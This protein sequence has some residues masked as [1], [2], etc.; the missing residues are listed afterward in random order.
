MNTRSGDLVLAAITPKY[1]AVPALSLETQRRL[2]RLWLLLTDAA[3]LALAFSIAFWMRFGLL[4]TVEPEVVPNQMF[5]LGLTA[6]LIPVWIL[7]FL[8]FNLYN[9]QM[10]L[11]GIAEYARAFNACTTSSMIVVI[12]AFL[13]PQLIISRAWLALS[14][15]LTFLLV[16]SNR[17][18]NRRLVYTLRERGYFLTP[19]AIIGTNSEA[20]TLA[21]DLGELRHSGLR[22]VGFVRSDDLDG[23]NHPPAIR[24]LG[25]LREIQTIITAHEIEDLIVATTALKRDEL[26]QLGEEV[27][28]IPNVNLR[29]SSGLYELFTT[30]VTVKTIGTVPL[31]S[32][33][34]VR[35]EPEEIYIKSLMDY[36]L[37]LAILFFA[38]PIYLLI[39]LLVKLDSPGPVL[40]RRRVLGGSNRQFDA[41]K[42][43]TMY[44]N[45]DELL[46]DKPELIQQLGTDHK[47]KNDPR[48]TKLGFWL[49]RFSLDELPQLFNVLMGQ[50]SLVGPRMITPAERDK[51][52]LHKLNLLT[53]KPGITGLWQVSGRSDVSYEDRVRL[54][55][56]YIR[57]YSVWLDLQI[58]FVQTLPAVFKS[59]GAY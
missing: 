11:G 9:L 38:W 7:A 55:M 21:S 17:F 41:L 44:V 56:Y 6:I 58:L 40:H 8:I 33:N 25:S 22:I 26:L 32:V 34:K 20:L 51:Y 36:T 5:Y 16:A 35:L 27:N 4:I 50:M 24:V 46:K 1:P 31:L 19:A 30:G 28:V 14:W 59:R 54:D 52:G 57:N 53:V 37:T 42:F 48:V 47:L 13:E 23:E 10:K 2:L 39:A 49:R 43:R 29:L 12:V 3:A 45:G 15:M 18:V